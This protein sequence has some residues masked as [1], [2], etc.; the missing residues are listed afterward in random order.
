MRMLN[1]F[2]ADMH[3]GDWINAALL[4]VTAGSLIWA[5]RQLK[6]QVRAT[7]FSNYFELMDRIS[8]AVRVYKASPD[9]D[10]AFDF[11]EVANLIEGV[12]HLCV[13]G[14]VK[15][16]S[17]EMITDYLSEMLP[18]IY[19]DKDRVTELFS[20]PDTFFYTRRFARQNDISSLLKNLASGKG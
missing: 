13:K 8:N 15:G 20:G 4:L 19:S 1:A 12:C 10:K 7:D 16:A 17:L 18:T 2:L 14:A 3:S 9:A 5:G 11:S 6:A